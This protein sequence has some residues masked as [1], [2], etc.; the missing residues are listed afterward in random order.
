MRA[1][2]PPAGEVGGGAHDRPHERQLVVRAVQAL[3]VEQFRSGPVELLLDQQGLKRRAR[4]TIEA[5]D[6]HAPNGRVTDP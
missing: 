4:E 1:F 2:A 5:G 6:D 3:P